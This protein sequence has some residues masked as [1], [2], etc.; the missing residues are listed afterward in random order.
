MITLIENS[1][2]TQR[3]YKYKRGA[4]IFSI[5]FEHNTD[6]LSYTAHIRHLRYKLK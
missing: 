6:D 2:Y 4:I 3:I 1:D 5:D